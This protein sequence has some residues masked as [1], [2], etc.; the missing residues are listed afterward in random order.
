[1]LTSTRPLHREHGDAKSIQ[2]ELTGILSASPFNPPNNFLVFPSIYYPFLPFLTNLHYPRIS[3]QRA[4]ASKRLIEATSLFKT[5]QYEY[6]RR[7]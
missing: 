5:P 7:C 2:T 4:P 3:I 1:M 6:Q